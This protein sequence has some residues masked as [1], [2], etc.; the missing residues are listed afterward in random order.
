[1]ADY[2]FCRYGAFERRAVAAYGERFVDYDF[3]GKANCRG[4]VGEDAKGKATACDGYWLCRVFLWLLFSKSTVPIVIGIMG[5]GYSM[6]GIYPTTVSFCG[7]LI[8]KY[9]MA[10][11]FILTLASF[12]SILMPMIIGRIAE[13][14]GIQWGIRSIIVVVLIDLLLIVALQFYIRRH[15]EEFTA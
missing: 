10:W 2:V 8:Q 9:S 12:G 3:G 11:S 6:A 13:S 5:F 4:A 1:M 7:G 15:Q 14:V